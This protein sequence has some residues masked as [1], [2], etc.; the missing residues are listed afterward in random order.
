LIILTC[1]CVVLSM[2]CGGGGNTG[3]SPDSKPTASTKAPAGPAP[4]VIAV[5]TTD[6]AI[7]MA[8]TIEGGWVTLELKNSGTT[9]HMIRLRKATSMQDAERLLAL[10]RDPAITRTALDAAAAHIGGVS[11]VTPGT[12]A[13]VTLNLPPGLYNVADNVP[14]AGV[15]NFRKGL[16]RTLTVTAANG[17]AAQEPVGTATLTMKD[18]SYSTFPVLPVG[19]ST[20]KF[21]NDGPESHTAIIARLNADTTVSTAFQRLV[22]INAGTVERGSGPLWETMGGLEGSGKGLTAY[23]TVSLQAGDYIFFCGLPD[24]ATGKTHAALGMVSGFTVR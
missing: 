9:A 2:S 13:Q 23:I 1:V 20:I 4:R 11:P 16:A 7:N 22:A 15:P 17:A 18:N 21:L 3:T 14:S 8:E 6:S 12:S 19:Q 24:P 5:E 10:E